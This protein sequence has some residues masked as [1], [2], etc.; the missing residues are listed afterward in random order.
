MPHALEHTDRAPQ[1]LVAVQEQEYGITLG[2]VRRTL[3]NHAAVADRPAKRPHLDASPDLT[4]V[5]LA[6]ANDCDRLDTTVSAHRPNVD[7]LAFNDDLGAR[8]QL[9]DGQTAQ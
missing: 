1:A 9:A 8:A 4:L 7:D 5:N 3:D 6:H 2:E